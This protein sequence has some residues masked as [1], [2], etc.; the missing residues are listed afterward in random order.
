MLMLRTWQAVLWLLAAAIA[1]SLVARVVPSAHFVPFARAHPE[2]G[3]AAPPGG[4]L[5]VS[6]I[7]AGPARDW[8]GDGVF[9]SRKDE[10]LE[11]VNTG[12]APL[13]L[14][15]YRVSDADS[16]IRYEFSGILQPGAVMLVTGSMA[17]AQQR[18]LGRTATGLSLNNG[19]DVVILFRVENG[20]TVGV[21]G[22]HYNTI[23]GA[24]DRSTG[25]IDDPAAWVLFDKLN[26]YTG[27]G[28]PKGTGCAPTPGIRNGCPTPASETTWGKIKQLYLER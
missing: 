28:E 25:W 9:D 2:G 3:F 26:P 27:S 19:G 7:L 8:D 14:A 6:E 15:P 10:W 5:Q 24:L 13:D 18:A 23:E 4:A 11:V 12:A 1:L 17:E 20:D 16:T 22:R 21:G